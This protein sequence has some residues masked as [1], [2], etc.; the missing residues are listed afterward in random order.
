MTQQEIIQ[1]QT[2]AK[3]WYSLYESFLGSHPSS[4]GNWMTWAQTVAEAP[5]PYKYTLSP[6]PSVLTKGNFPNLDPSILNS[7]QQKLIHYIEI[8]CSDVQGASCSGPKP[9]RP[10][11]HYMVLNNSASV[12]IFVSCPAGYN[13]LG[14]GFER[15]DTKNYEQFPSYLCTSNTTAHCYDYFGAT[16]YAIC[17]NVIQPIFQN[18]TQGKTVSVQCPPGYLVTGCAMALVHT[19]T[20]KWPHAYMIDKQTCECYDFWGVT[21]CQASCAPESFL[22][23]HGYEIISSYGKGVVD[24]VCSPGKQVLGCGFKPNEKDQVEVRWDVHPSNDRCICYN[25]FGVSC[26]AVCANLYA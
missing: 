9:D 26:Y 4:D 14:T 24:V 1:A 19:Y 18:V 13:L 5:Y 7:T 21:T 17:T 2:Y 22:N 6:I 10:P 12:D 8:Y 15:I 3:N 16:C 11:I 23:A 25:Y 20:E